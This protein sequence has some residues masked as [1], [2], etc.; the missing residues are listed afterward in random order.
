MVSLG[1]GIHFIVGSLFVP[2]GDPFCFSPTDKLV[3]K[4]AVSVATVSPTNQVT[5]TNQIVA[6]R[7][8]NLCDFNDPNSA[9]LDKEFLSYDATTRTLV[10]SYTK[11]FENF[12]VHSGNGQIELVRAH[13]PADPTTLA[14]TDF[15][16]PVVV[17]A[18]R[19]RGGEPGRVPGGR[20][21]GHDLRGL[22][23]QHRQQPVQRRSLCVSP[24]RSCAAQRDRP[25]R[26][27]PEPPG[28]RH[29]GPGELQRLGWRALARFGRDR[30]LQPWHGQRLPARSPST[31]RWA[32]WWPSGTTPASTHWA[33]SG[34]AP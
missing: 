26:R 9:F 24:C 18:R 2:A 11:F 33:T 20:P 16:Q 31:R 17:S 30:G 4:L 32:R 22:G 25:R 5:F 13:L 27:W 14:K 34:Y 19:G 23:A 7:G 15:S 12:S 6:A 8:G 1:D 29:L 28:V 21:G 3:S 10:M